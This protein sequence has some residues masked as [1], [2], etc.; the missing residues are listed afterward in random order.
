[1][2][3]VFDTQDKLWLHHSVYMS[4]DGELYMIKQSVFGGFKAPI[5]LSGDRYVYH[6]AINLWDKNGKAVFEG[7]YIQAQVDENRSVVGLV[8]YAQE[9]SSYVILCVDCDEFYTLG[10]EVCEYIEVVGNVFD[11]YEVNQNDEQTLYEQEA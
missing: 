6:K 9:L 3:R 4:L 7:D 2:F 11:G 1:M 8:C 5:A 10:T